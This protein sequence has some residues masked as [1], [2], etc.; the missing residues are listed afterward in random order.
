MDQVK[1]S[2]DEF[3]L[4]YDSTEKVT[5]RRLDTNRWN[6]TICTG[7]LIAIA[8]ITK[9]GTS[10]QILLWVAISA[11]IILSL[12]AILFC[13]LW[14]RQIL[15]YKHLNNAKFEILNQ[16]SPMLEFDRTGPDRIQSFSPFSKEWTILTKQNAVQEMHKTSIIALKSSNIE[17][18]IPKAFAA[19]YS[20]IIVGISIIIIVYWPPQRLTTAIIK[21]DV[22]AQQA[23]KP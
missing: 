4:Y 10:N 18:F 20:L 15:D 14:I 5:D 2:Y 7:I 16:M 19:L 22:S 12:M 1:Y 6:Y 8:I 13:A 21:P 11:D 3:K 9:W 23:T 17:F